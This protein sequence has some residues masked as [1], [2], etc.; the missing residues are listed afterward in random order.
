MCG[1][2]IHDNSS[3]QGDLL[4][5]Q[6]PTHDAHAKIS[7]E[8]AA[9]L[10]AL[11][12]AARIR[13]VVLP[14]SRPSDEPARGT[15]RAARIEA[16]KQETQRHFAEVDQVL[17][18]CGGRRLSEQGNALGFIAVEATPA[19]VHALCDLPWVHTILEDQPIHPVG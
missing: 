1:N 3:I 4:S 13:S 7:H 5:K 2:S 8:F 11:P 14:T 18:T 17:A 9:R 12:P 16:A 19:A 10:A 15:D 6:T